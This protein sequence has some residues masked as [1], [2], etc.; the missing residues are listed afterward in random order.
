MAREPAS[1]PIGQKRRWYMDLLPVTVCFAL[2]ISVG[3]LPPDTSK[4]EV[5]KAGRLNV[6]M[7]SQYAP[8]VTRNR[9]MPGFEVELVRE[10]AD[11]QG[12]RLNIVSNAA[13]GRDFN[14]RNWRINRAQCQMLAGGIA[15]NAS[16]RSFLDTS[17][18]HL[19]T[20]WAVVAKPGVTLDQIEGQ[21]GF[22]AGLTGLDRLALGQYLRGMGVSPKIIN[23]GPALLGAV[24]S[25]QVE[26]GISEAL[27]AASTFGD[28]EYDVT[29]MGEPIQRFPLGMGFWKGDTTLQMTVQKTLSDIWADGTMVEIAARYDLD[30]QFLCEPDEALCQ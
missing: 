1:R 18:P 21:V 2:L 16:T 12:W 29:L 14:P 23:S 10:I 22:F 26:A 4:A 8:L 30:E 20:G 5:D 3:F 19:L 28:T 9:D 25:G 7:P 27:L 17:N 15:I 6:C 13:M 11:R 24:E